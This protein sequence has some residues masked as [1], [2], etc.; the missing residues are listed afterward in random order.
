MRSGIAI[1]LLATVALGIG[2]ALAK[3]PFG[4]PKTGVGRR[5]VDEGVEET[6]AAN[7]VTSVVVS[8][9][10]YDTLGEVAFLFI[11]ATG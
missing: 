7:I 1:V 11:A 5:Y 2:L 8:Y 3:V 4:D 9:R 6:G 10:G